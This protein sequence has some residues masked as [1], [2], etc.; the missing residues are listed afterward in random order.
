MGKGDMK[1]WGLTFFFLFAN[2]R[3]IF[4]FV[5]RGTCDLDRASSALHICEDVP[6]L[7]VIGSWEGCG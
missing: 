4:L 1:V 7:T 2:F 6:A 5:G 3:L